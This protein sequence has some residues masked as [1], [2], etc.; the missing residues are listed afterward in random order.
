[1]ILSLVR[2]KFVLT[3]GEDRSPG[4]MAYQEGTRAGGIQGEARA[5]LVVRM[6]WEAVQGPDLQLSNGIS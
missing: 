4:E 6:A 2:V 5:C 1:M 3:L